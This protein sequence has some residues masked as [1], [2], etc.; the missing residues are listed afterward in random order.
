MVMAA[1]VAMVQMWSKDCVVSLTGQ[2]ELELD[3]AIYTSLTLNPTNHR[4]FLHASFGYTSGGVN[5]ITSMSV[6]KTYP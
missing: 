3:L 4:F 6:G 5:R 2:T 1:R